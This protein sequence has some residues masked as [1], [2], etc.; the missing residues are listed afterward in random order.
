MTAFARARA[1][2]HRGDDERLITPQC[3]RYGQQ[4]AG[5]VTGAHA[6]ALTLCLVPQ[7]A[8]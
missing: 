3:G 1:R 2:A 8:S 6:A 4:I 5:T 7:D